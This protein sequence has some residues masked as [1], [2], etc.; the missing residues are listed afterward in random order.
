MQG[1]DDE[2]IGSFVKTSVVEYTRLSEVIV[3]WDS[4]LEL[5]PL[6]P[7]DTIKLGLDPLDSLDKT[8]LGWFSSVGLS[9]LSSLWKGF[10]DFLV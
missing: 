7:W 3:D 5:D 4:A 6:D 8:Q 2:N 9:G 1:I 10:N